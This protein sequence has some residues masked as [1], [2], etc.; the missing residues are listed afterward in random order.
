ML[1]RAVERRDQILRE[2]EPDW[3][4]EDMQREIDQIVAAAERELF[5]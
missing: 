4:E 3:L 2:H 1:D 5:G